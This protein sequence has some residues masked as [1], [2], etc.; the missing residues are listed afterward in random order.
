VRWWDRKRDGEALI[1]RL[2]AERRILVELILKEVRKLPSADQDIR[3]V[4]ETFVV[5]RY[6]PELNA[7]RARRNRYRNIFW[8]AGLRISEALSLTESDLDAIR[9]SVLVRCGKRGK[10]R[11]VRMDFWAWQQLNNWLEIRV[12]MRVGALLCVIDGLT[13][14][15]PWSPPSGRPPLHAHRV[16]I[17]GAN[18]LPT[19]RDP[20]H[21]CHITR[22]SNMPTSGS[23]ASTCKES[24]AAKSST[25]SIG[26]QR[27]CF[28]PAPDSD[29]GG[30]PKQ[31]VRAGPSSW[32]KDRPS[33]QPVTRG[34]APSR[35]GTKLRSMGDTLS[36]QER[37]RA[38]RD[39][40]TRS[41]DDRTVLIGMNRPATPAELRAF[42][43]R[44]QAR[45][46]AERE[47]ASAG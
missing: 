42:V 44:E 40:P 43:A 30:R 10:R 45:I 18:P 13:A 27:R 21:S 11:E 36:A 1:K 46:R 14:G 34:V 28:P 39:A 23:P 24:T 19:C 12:A 17:P 25:L 15:R 38:E 20:W 4:R 7:W 29:N 3:V 26:G 31:Q 9:G 5:Y 6:A 8:R 32:T 2:N 22:I 37:R 47:H 16:A 41:D 35:A 33:A